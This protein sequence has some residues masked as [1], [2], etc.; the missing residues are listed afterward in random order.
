MG[1]L[2][3][4]FRNRYGDKLKGSRNWQAKIDPDDRV[5]LHDAMLNGSDWGRI[6][7]RARA[8]TAVR[9]KGRFA[10]GRATR[11]QKRA[12]RRMVAKDNSGGS[13]EERTPADLDLHPEMTRLFW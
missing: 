2:K 8:A 3:N 7:G 5:V 11:A 9:I 13:V 10:P 4:F 6:G 12:F 1:D